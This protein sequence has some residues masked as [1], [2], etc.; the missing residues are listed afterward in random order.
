M[1]LGDQSLR[2]FLAATAEASPAPGGGSAAA[3]TCALAAALVEMASG[4][5]AG[6]GASSAGEIPARARAIREQAV[7]LAERELTSYAPVLDARRLDRADPERAARIEAA[8]LEASRSPLE[9][10]EAGAEVAQL[11]A[12]VASDCDPSVRGDALAGVLL[13]EAAAASASGLVEINLKGG[14]GGARDEL[15]ERA[16]TASRRAAGARAGAD[17][18]G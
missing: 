13:G 12:A 14:G 5:E 15:L 9:I 17:E 7:V 3:A 2:G 11:G 6:R 1:T 18:R 4:I 10:A 8:L 16:R